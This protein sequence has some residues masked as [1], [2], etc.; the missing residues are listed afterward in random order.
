MREIVHKHRKE[1][2]DFRWYEENKTVLNEA[3]WSAEAFLRRGRLNQDLND[4]KKQTP[5]GCFG[6]DHD[7]VLKAQKRHRFF[8][9]GMSRKGI[10]KGRVPTGMGSANGTGPGQ[11]SFISS[12]AGPEWV[13]VSY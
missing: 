6:R 12:G 2:S 10:P 13:C 9:V 4:K 11:C 1:H 7:I 5:E 3:E 8:P